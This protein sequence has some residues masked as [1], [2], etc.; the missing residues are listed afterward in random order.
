M[1]NPDKSKAKAGKAGAP[2]T[3]KAVRDPAQQIWLAGLGAFAKA[4][5][6]GGKMFEAL[7]KEG[8]SRQ[9]KTQADAE[10]KLAEATQRMSALASGL[11][12]LSGLSGL[13]AQVARPWGGLENI[14]EDRVAKALG[15]LGVPSSRDLDALAVRL[16]ALERRVQALSGAGAGA[17]GAATKPVKT[18]AKTAVKRAARK[19]AG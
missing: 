3:P 5:E 15:A 1:K 4:H 17:E 10:A 6:E 14:F 7:V 16:D 9:R 12:G 18:A 13:S 2:Q 8:L 19:S 11:P